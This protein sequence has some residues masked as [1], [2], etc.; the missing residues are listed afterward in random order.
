MSNRV[1]VIIIYFF[2]NSPLSFAT[3]A[4]SKTKTIITEAPTEL[5]ADI[6]AELE[7]Q[8]K[9]Y[10]KSRSK[11]APKVVPNQTTT[12]ANSEEDPVDSSPSRPTQ[13]RSQPNPEDK[14]ALLGYSFGTLLF[15]QNFSTTTKVKAD[16]TPLTLTTKTA[17]FQNAG[18][19]IRYSNIPFDTVGMDYS[20]AIA[21][22]INHN[23]SNYAAI[24]SIK[25]D[26]N[27][28]YAR[29][30][31]DKLPYYFLA[32]VGYQLL[33]GSSIT[34]LV[35]GGAAVF[36]LSSG[37][38]LLKSLSIEVG[39]QYSK[40]T[41]SSDFYD[42]LETAIRAQGVTSVVFDETASSAVSNVILG[43]LTYKF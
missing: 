13:R 9:K 37:L 29:Q 24:T 19:V 28:S 22:S 3:E 23:S 26:F 39:Y 25:L 31:A 8:Q 12:E 41:L 6:E 40:Y 32:G 36:Q 38:I 27:L 18:F 7:Q 35:S 14:Y 5:D 42:T 10:K 1:F 34:N 20:G 17:D 43:R 21:T 4:A 15:I 16:S 11:V 33:N 2:V 30:T